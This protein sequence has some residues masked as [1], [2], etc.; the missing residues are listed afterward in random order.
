MSDEAP[1][2]QGDAYLDLLKR[3]LLG[4][5]MGPARWYR[6]V[7]RTS[8]RAKTAIA[9][10][11]DRRGKTVLAEPVEIDMARNVDGRFNAVYLPPGV[12]TMVGATRLDNVADCVRSVLADDVPGDLI[13]T[14]VWRGGTSIFMRGL[15]RAN[16]VSDRKVY[17]ADS[18]A[19]LPAP[20]VERY[21]ADAGIDLHLW[22]ELAVSVDEVQANFRR[23]G[24]LDPQVVFVEGWFR[25]T[26]PALQGHPWA[27]LRLDGDLYE[28]TM[29]ALTYLYPGLSVGGWVIIDDYQIPACAQAVTDYRA[30]HDVSDAIVTVDWT[31]VCWRKTTGPTGQEASGPQIS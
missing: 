19:G 3:S 20:D 24:L 25:D 12:M 31:G 15:L 27:V 22:S 30:R 17:V 7:R 5:T 14:G 28:S 16:G 11:L 2:E 10:A 4:L 23:Y 8:N 21:P 1:G 18:F 26:L 6:P 13:E 29:D 9:T